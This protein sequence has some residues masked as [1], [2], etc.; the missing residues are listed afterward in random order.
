MQ[1]PS[2]QSLPAVVRQLIG[3][4]IG[5]LVAF[6]G[7]QAY[8]WTAPKV[9]AMFTESVQVESLQDATKLREQRMETVNDIVSRA[10]EILQKTN[11]DNI[12]EMN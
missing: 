9:L 5:A 1:F 10:Q 8:E 2:F 12:V 3:A 4:V 7:Y 11:T 6:V